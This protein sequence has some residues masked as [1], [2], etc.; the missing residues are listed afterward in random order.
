MCKLEPDIWMRQHRDIYEDIAVYID[1]LEI[2]AM[3]SKSLMH[4][5]ETDIS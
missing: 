5:L 1:D 3:H 2:A 4:A